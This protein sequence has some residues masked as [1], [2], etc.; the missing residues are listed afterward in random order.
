ME[1]KEN[2]F[3]NK[4]DGKVT[5]EDHLAN[6]GWFM[7]AG[8]VANKKTRNEVDVMNRTRLRKIK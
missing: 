4:R 3:R 8:L 7:Y 2:P 1:C 5:I 6:K